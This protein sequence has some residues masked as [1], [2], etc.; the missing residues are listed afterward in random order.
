MLENNSS[1][2]KSNL[3]NLRWNFT[4]FQLPLGVRH[5]KKIILGTAKI[6]NLGTKNQSL[7]YSVNAKPAKIQTKKRERKEKKKRRK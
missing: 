7:Q 2:Y 3:H 1:R 6:F 5:L 4:A